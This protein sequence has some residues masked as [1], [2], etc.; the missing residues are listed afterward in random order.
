M[1]SR[2]RRG[3]LAAVAA[4]LLA[5]AC[6]SDSA[7]QWCAD[8]LRLLDAVHSFR[9]LSELPRG[10]A[11][12]NQVSGAANVSAAVVSGAGPDAKE[13]FRALRTGVVDLD[14]TLSSYGYDLL[15][16]Q[17]ESDTAEQEDL[18]ALDGAVVTAAL[19]V[20]GND[21]NQQCQAP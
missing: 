16:A 15:R 11:L 9:D 19:I 10:D 8:S 1:V 2:G 6:T 14:R 4:L 18:L 12:K 13:A 3:C 5:S 20:A 17:S 7:A 21:R